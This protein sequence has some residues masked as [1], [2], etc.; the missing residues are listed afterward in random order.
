MQLLTGH[1][2]A[3]FPGDFGDLKNMDMEQGTMNGTPVVMPGKFGSH[4]GVIDLELKK[5]RSMGCY[6]RK[7]RSA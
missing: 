5:R 7:R 6:Q 4:L 2:H 1:N 3:V